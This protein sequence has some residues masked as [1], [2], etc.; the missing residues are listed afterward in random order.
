MANSVGYYGHA[1]RA[2]RLTVLLFLLYMV[3]FELIAA[4]V[5]AIPLMA[6][7]PD[8][9]PITNPVGYALRYAL[10]VAVLSA[11]IFWPLYR[12]HAAA[13]LRSLNAREPQMATD[14]RFIRIAQ[15]QCTALGVRVPQLG[16]IDSPALNVVTVGEGP[17]RGLIAATSGIIDRLDDDELAAVLAH[18]ASHIRNG[19]TKLLA[20]NHAL[21]RTAAVLQT[22]NPLRFEDWRQGLII[23]L[24]PPILLLMLLSSAITMLSMRLAWLARR[25][26]RI[27]RDY[28]ADGE[29]IRITHFPEALVSALQKS[30]GQG[31]FPGSDRFDQLLFVAGKE[32]ESGSRPPIDD[33]INAIMTLG[34]QLLQP[35]RA[36]RDT[37][38]GYAS[39]GQLFGAKPVRPIVKA[40]KAQK[41]DDVTL[42]M[43]LTDP[44]RAF[45]LQSAWIDWYQWRENDDRGPL[46]IPLRL[47]LPI[48]A[49]ALLSIV[50]FFPLDGDLRKFG[51]TFNP[52]QLLA[53]SEQT[54][55]TF[56]AG[57]HCPE[58]KPD[59]PKRIAVSREAPKETP[60]DNLIQAILR[61][62]MPVLPMLILFAL[63][64]I[65]FVQKRR[66][67]ST[68]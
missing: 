58:S 51:Q 50:L 67:A 33:R 52:T 23:V 49:A 37:R 65:M 30:R 28:V 24:I 20:A 35:D 12:G 66:R 5:L 68:R 63:P 45:A 3:A 7:D 6:F 46:G 44:K 26:L 48:G 4:F 14:L 18:E 21:M 54:Q 42:T 47:A 59:G 2:T 32:I 57:K 55:G 40:V 62:I 36:R 1:R 25:S 29:A 43:L 10:P 8:Y 11:V 56:C 31:A 39:P 64:F 60:P 27:G 17:T 16:I 53:M 41:P 38:T 13:V 61:P 15:A 19:D 9:W 22:H 34:Q